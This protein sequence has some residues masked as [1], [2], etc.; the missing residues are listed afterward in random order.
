[1]LKMQFYLRCPAGELTSILQCDRFRTLLPAV[2][3]VKC[4]SDAGH[5]ID[6]KAVSGA[7]YI[8]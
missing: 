5:F 4:V 3:K 7:Q 1:M 2:A 6:V 8:E